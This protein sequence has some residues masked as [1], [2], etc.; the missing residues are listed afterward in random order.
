MY[1]H[2]THIPRYFQNNFTSRT[3][4]L[5]ENYKNDQYMNILNQDNIYNIDQ[6]NFITD[7]NINVNNNYDYNIENNDYLNNDENFDFNNQNNLT[8]QNDLN[9][10]IDYF[11]NKLN[12]INDKLKKLKNF[13]NEI[14]QT[15][16][17][18]HDK[19]ALNTNQGEYN[20]NNLKKAK[21]SS[22][23]DKSFDRYKKKKKL[24]QQIIKIMTL[25]SIV[26]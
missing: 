21:F 14:E 3:M 20:N 10:N 26:I 5:E 12:N 24:N 7:D 4:P 2:N 16:S 18:N 19:S 9:N 15:I 6:N 13:Q 23:M 25:Y 22:N 8:S 11:Q 17:I 1:G